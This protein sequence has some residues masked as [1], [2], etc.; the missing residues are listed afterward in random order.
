VIANL[1]CSDIDEIDDF[2]FEEID[3][4]VDDEMIDVSPC[5]LMKKI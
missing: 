3:A 5:E 2:G 4:E 1:K